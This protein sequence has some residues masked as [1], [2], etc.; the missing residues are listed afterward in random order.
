MPFGTRH[1][2]QFFQRTSDAV[3]YVLG[4]HGFDVLNYIDDVLGFGVP[5]VASKSYQALLQVM[6]DL[7]LTI[8]EKKLVPPSTKAVCLSIDIDRVQGTLSIPQEKF[9]QIKVKVEN[10]AHKNKCTK[11]QLQSLLGLLLYICAGC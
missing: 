3:R 6:T 9:A 10:W 7:G 1:G 2:S 11:R 8:S 4:M 5:S